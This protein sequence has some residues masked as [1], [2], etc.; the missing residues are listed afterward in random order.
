MKRFIYTILMLMLPLMV[1]AQK[2]TL[3]SAKTKD[4][5]DYNGEMVS[6]K[7]NGKGRTIYKNGNSY[8]GEYVKGKRQGYG[9]YTFADGEKYEGEIRRR[10]VSGSAARTR[11]LLLPE[12]QP[13]R[14]SLVS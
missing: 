1:G 3:G 7:P 10:V 5:G 11:H 4:G 6:G 2:I 12:Q 8:E 9:V 13:L 14:G